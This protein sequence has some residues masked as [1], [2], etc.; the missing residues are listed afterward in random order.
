MWK[1][2]NNNVKNI[3]ILKIGCYGQSPL[4]NSKTLEFKRNASINCLQ[5]DLYIIVP[6]TPNR[7]N[8]KHAFAAFHGLANLITMA[9]ISETAKATMWRIQDF[10]VETVMASA[11]LPFSCPSL[12]SPLSGGAEYITPEKIDFHIAVREF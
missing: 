2:A 1:T 5:Q 9:S 4:E 11:N 3:S 10:L 8:D 7:R 12:P 6:K